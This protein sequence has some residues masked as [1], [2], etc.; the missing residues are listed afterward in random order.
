MRKLTDDLNTGFILEQG[1]ISG[2]MIKIVI[3][4]ITQFSDQKSHYGIRNADKKFVSIGQ[5]VQSEKILTKA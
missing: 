4:D 5:L 2:E 3:D 1:F